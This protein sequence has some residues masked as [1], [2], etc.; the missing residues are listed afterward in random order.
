MLSKNIEQTKTGY[1]RVF[2]ADEPNRLGTATGGKHALRQ[3]GRQLGENTHHDKPRADT[4]WGMFWAYPALALTKIGKTDKMWDFG[5]FLAKTRTPTMGKA[6]G[7]KHAPRQTAG[8]Y[9]MGYVLGLPG[10]GLD[11]NWQN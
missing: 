5:H 7:G 6:T 3:W 4:L 11:Q 2:S 1:Q 8:R 10:L 9:P